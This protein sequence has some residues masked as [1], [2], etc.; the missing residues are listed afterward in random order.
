ML[1]TFYK[2]MSDL[3]E[4]DGPTDFMSAHLMPLHP[5]D[6]AEALPSVPTTLA[7]KSASTASTSEKVSKLPAAQAGVSSPQFSSKPR[8]QQSPSFKNIPPMKYEVPSPTVPRPQGLQKD[9]GIEEDL[10]GMKYDTGPKAKEE[11]KHDYMDVAAAAL[12]AAKSADRAVAAA[13]AAADLARKHKEH[14]SKESNVVRQDSRDAAQDDSSCTDLDSDSEDG[15]NVAVK[16]ETS[17]SRSKG[18][19]NPA[20]TFDTDSDVEEYD[21]PRGRGPSGTKA[22]HQTQSYK[23]VETHGAY[24][25]REAPSKASRLDF[26]SAEASRRPIF[27]DDSPKEV[28]DSIFSRAGKQERDNRSY[29]GDSTSGK[30]GGGLKWHSKTTPEDYEP[31]SVNREE[32]LNPYGAFKSTDYYSKVDE[33]EGEDLQSRSFK[34]STKFEEPHSG[35]SGSSKLASKSQD[36]PSLF[37]EEGSVGRSQ[38]TSRFGTSTLKSGYDEDIALPASSPPKPAFD[39]LPFSVKTRPG[40]WARRGLRTRDSAGQVFGSESSPRKDDY[41]DVQ[42]QFDNLKMKR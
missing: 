39:D 36:R 9:E 38:K 31:I 18:G 20:P 41:D 2:S 40:G 24:A 33:F 37:V 4:Q 7:N 13:Q 27:D 35:A 1:L 29:G 22:K 16:A 30:K 11:E 19:S 23:P 15:G 8:E 6:K 5:S 12:A 25:H 26:E 28:E 3:F 14:E 10:R 42:T 21:V 32:S 17:Q 34:R